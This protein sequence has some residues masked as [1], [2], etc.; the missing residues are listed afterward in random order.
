VYISFSAITILFVYIYLISHM[1]DLYIKH[2]HLVRVVVI[3][4]TTSRMYIPVPEKRGNK[5][6][7]IPYKL[8]SIHRNQPRLSATTF[9]VEPRIVN[10]L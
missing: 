9:L 5:Q 2:Y 6:Q 10:L 4:I 7:P 3:Y 1:Y 8:N